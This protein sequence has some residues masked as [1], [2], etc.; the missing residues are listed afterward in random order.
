MKSPVFL[1]NLRRM[2]YRGVIPLSWHTNRIYL[3]T[4]TVGSSLIH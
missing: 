3:H 1:P 4:R 2:S